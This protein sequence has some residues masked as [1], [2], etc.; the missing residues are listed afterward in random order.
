MRNREEG[1]SLVEVL[2]ALAVT[3]VTMAIAAR[4]LIG[5][6]FLFMAAA[7]EARDPVMEIVVRQLRNDI[8]G[9]SGVDGGFGGV[10]WSSQPLDLVGH[11][12]Y[13]RIS[14]RRTSDLRLVR[15]F[16]IDGRTVSRDLLHGVVSWRWIDAA[17]LLSLQISIRRQ[18]WRGDPL[19]PSP[20]TLEPQPLEELQWLSFAMRGEGLAHGW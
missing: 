4:L 16:V 15:S 2:V 5:S 6:Q 9:S 8:Q 17:G 20:R 1:V 3:G 14:Y 18:P 12:R 7:R 19:N 10:D 13:D 11:A